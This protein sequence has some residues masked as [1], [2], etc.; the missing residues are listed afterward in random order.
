MGGGFAGPGHWYWTWALPL[1][2]LAR[3]RVWLAMSGLVLVY[4]L[5]F[6]LRCHFPDTPVLG[7]AYRGGVFFDLVVT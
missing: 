2:P 1:L 7:I 4:Y 6:W 5:R 3:S